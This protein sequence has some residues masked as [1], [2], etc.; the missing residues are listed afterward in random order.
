MTLFVERH[1]SRHSIKDRRAGGVGLGVL[2]TK[3]K[4]FR[5]SSSGVIQDSGQPPILKCQIPS[6]A[7][8]STSQPSRTQG[9]RD[10]SQTPS[11][12]ET[13]A[14]QVYHDDEACV[15]SR[16]PG[17]RRRRWQSDV[18]MLSPEHDTSSFPQQS[19]AFDF[20]NGSTPPALY[21]IMDQ[22]PGFHDMGNMY[23]D[24]TF[25]LVHFNVMGFTPGQHEL[26]LPISPPSQ[27]LVQEPVDSINSM[28][29]T[30]REQHAQTDPLPP[31]EASSEPQSVSRIVSVSRK[32]PSSRQRV[33]DNSTK[34]PGDTPELQPSNI[35][36]RDATTRGTAGHEPGGQS[37]TDAG[38]GSE[39]PGTVS[40]VLAISPQKR[41]E[42]LEFIGEIRPVRPNGTLIDDDSPDFGLENLQNYLDLF[43]EFFNTTY[44][45]VHVATLNIGDIDPIALLSM[46]LLGATYKDKDAHQL[47]VCLYDALIPYILSGLL[48]SP[49]PDLSILQSFLILECYG[50]YR[51]GPYQRENAI[52]I[53]A[54][55]WN[56]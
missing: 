42:L 9:I 38:A 41:E 11:N 20:A 48:G 5:D 24:M 30:H 8:L 33:Q 2:E 37:N 21:D 6:S 44:P 32:R 51:A 47:S 34:S 45:I 55:L 13:L 39:V 46:I 49:A 56:V 26:V 52:L 54:L 27:A 3:S 7:S 28:S 4:H 10:V 16:L 1:K 19:H 31:W 53:H 36:N 25:D 23:H 12:V 40:S 18:E 43:F 17:L 50:M 35:F 22:S 15:S 29:S 14:L